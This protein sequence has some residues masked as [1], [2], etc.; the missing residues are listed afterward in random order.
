MPTTK[1]EESLNRGDNYLK[2]LPFEEGDYDC[3]CA[4]SNHEGHGACPKLT[5]VKAFGIK[6][7][8]NLSKVIKHYSMLAT[9][10]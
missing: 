3:A 8:E 7:Q 2:T 9:R 5:I 4:L 10:T 6:F 1:K